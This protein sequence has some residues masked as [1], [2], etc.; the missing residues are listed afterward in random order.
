MS[1]F[2]LVAPETAAGQTKE[3]LS[4]VRGKLGLVPNMTRAMVRAPAVLD[5]YLQMSGALAKGALPAKV[6]EQIA[7]TVGQAN[8]CDY[9]LAAH[10]TLGKLVGLA[11]EQILAARTGHAADA[12]TDALLAFAK[13]VVEKRGR[14][15]VDDQA[16]VRAAGFGDEAIAE[17]VANVALNLFTNYFNHVAGTQIDFP[18]A[19]AL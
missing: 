8:E 9:C 12:S 15:D 1:S 2:T 17:I 11:P 18:A 19:P 10:S 3:L 6:R 7:L 5:A 13:I 14:V 4:A 16:R